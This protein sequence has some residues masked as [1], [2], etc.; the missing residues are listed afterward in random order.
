MAEKL[1]E[2]FKNLLHQGKADQNDFEIR[3]Y[4]Y[5]NG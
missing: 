2:L 3:F 1:R 4:T 5:Q